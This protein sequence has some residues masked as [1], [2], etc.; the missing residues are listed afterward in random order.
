MRDVDGGLELLRL[1]QL[2]SPGGELSEQV[3]TIVG[4]ICSTPSG[5]EAEAARAGLSRA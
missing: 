4:S 5:F 3:S 1:R 2:V